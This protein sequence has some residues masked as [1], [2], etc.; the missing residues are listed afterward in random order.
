MAKALTQTE[1]IKRSVE[2]HGNRY[3]Y[4]NVQ[5]K[6]GN[7]KV[8][9]VCS[10]HGKFLQ[11][12]S[13]HLQGQGCPLCGM[14]KTYNSNK[15]PILK[16]DFIKKAIERH[17]DKYDYS[18]VSDPLYCTKKVIITCPKHGDF[19][20]LP[21]R[22]LS[23]QS[24]RRCA[25]ALI[26]KFLRKTQ[27]DFIKKAL[28]KHN[29]KYNYS[30]VVYIKNCEK[31]IIIC[32]KHG[33]FKQSP[34]MHLQGNGC[35]KC[36]YEKLFDLRRSSTEEFISSSVARHGNKYS[37]S[38]VV[39]IR[40]CEKVMIICPKHGEFLQEPNTHLAG[41]G[42]PGCNN[43]RGENKIENWFKNR[44]IIFE[45]QKIFKDCKNIKYLRFDF[46]LPKNIVCVEYDGPQHFF[47]INWHEDVEF[48][49]IKKCDKI[50]EKYC[51]DKGIKLIRIPYTSFKS[52]E[53]T[54]NEKGF[55]C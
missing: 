22:H 46:Y 43:S 20:Q 26:G 39:Y 13:N 47:P 21:R 28:L 48:E 44:G 51:K 27:E 14:L 31:V 41:H 11:T 35:H 54:L 2:I 12:P 53:K 3:D 52:I 15:K 24:C 34:L 9:I 45:R 7:K 4:S 40:A 49:R 8:E 5:Y 33:E 19:L 50:K 16:S 30:K 37:Y 55:I 6:V 1:Y 23:G 36:H 10:I 38:K 32:P 17:G 29:C 25:R 18:K 42:C